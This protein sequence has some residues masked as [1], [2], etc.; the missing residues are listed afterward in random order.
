[1]T[2]LQAA[3]KASRYS[4]S[5]CG[6]PPTCSTRAQTHLTAHPPCAP[7]AC[8]FGSIPISPLSL[9]FSLYLPAIYSATAAAGDLAR[10]RGGGGGG[11][12]TSKAA[13]AHGGVRCAL[14]RWVVSPIPRKKPRTD[15]H[16]SLDF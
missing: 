6:S 14:L 8:P 12:R 13:T 1:M 16:F 3:N 5:T 10:G 15:A 9:G 11:E 4:G 7:I 2:L